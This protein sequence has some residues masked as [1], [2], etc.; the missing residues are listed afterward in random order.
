MAIVS[1]NVHGYS[2]SERGMGAAFE[3]GKKSMLLAYLFWFFLGNA[4]AHRFYCGKTR[5]AVTLLVLM[6]LGWL[7]LIFYIGLLVLIGV[8]LWV[9]IDAFRIP[10]WIRE[11]NSALAL[12][13]GVFDAGPSAGFADSGRE[14]GD[15]NAKAD[16][17]IARYVQ[18]AGQQSPR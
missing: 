14:Q 4:G 10:G 5:S 16:E 6:V 11:Y 18:N 7:T 12:H 1:E 8:G 17:A 2:Q 3:A 13:L 15:F 9:L